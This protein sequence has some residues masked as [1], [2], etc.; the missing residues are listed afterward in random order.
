[1]TNF[2]NN[3]SLKLC[4]YFLVI[5]RVYPVFFFKLSA[6]E[7]ME[8]AINNNNNNTRFTTFGKH[9]INILNTKYKVFTSRIQ[10][11]NGYFFLL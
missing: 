4:C 5:N 1:M 9:F 2:N 8:L 11:F 6:L 10:I 7:D 3:I